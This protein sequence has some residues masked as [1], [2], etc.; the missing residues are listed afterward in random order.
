MY[1]PWFVVR[2]V[3]I[4]EVEEVDLDLDGCDNI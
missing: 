2:F 3:C 1:P 4:G